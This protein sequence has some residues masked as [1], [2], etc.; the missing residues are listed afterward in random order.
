MTHGKA[1]GKR[2]KAKPVTVVAQPRRRGV[3]IVMLFAFCILPLAFHATPLAAAQSP[4]TAA[5]PFPSREKALEMAGA[6]VAGGRR[7]EAK[8]LLA[9]AGRRYQSAEALMQLARLQIQDGNSKGALD[10]LTKARTLA[11]NSE[12]VLYAFSQVALAGSAVTPALMSLQPLT[13]M[14]PDVVEYQYLFGVA[15]MQG[16]NMIYAYEALLRADQLEPDRPLTLIALG[17]VAN[18]RKMYAEAKQY[19]LKALVRQPDSVEGTAALA[20]AEDGLGDTTAAETHA[21]RVLEKEPY[22]ATALLVVGLALMKQQK[23]EDARDAFTRS[24]AAD[25]GE[26]KA[27][28][29]LSLA[30]ARMGDQVNSDRWRELFQQK[31]RELEDRLVEIRTRTGLPSNGGMG[32]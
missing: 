19:L 7:D 17:L 9:E 5:K 31:Q 25:P 18:R 4:R 10:A 8:R 32:H 3:T 21:R 11:P 22:N 29:Q 30:Y 16:G 23:F 15:L 6:S 27:Y 24:V 28:Y 1:R 26:P 20:E 12:G 2:Q 14:C 13:R